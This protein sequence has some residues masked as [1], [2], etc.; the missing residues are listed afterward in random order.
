MLA[1]SNTEFVTVEYELPDGTKGIGFTSLN[2]FWPSEVEGVPQ[3]IL[4]DPILIPA[5]AL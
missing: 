2:G 5:R 3:D 4:E 1:G